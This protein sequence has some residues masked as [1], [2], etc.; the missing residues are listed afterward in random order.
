MA[1][2]LPKGSAGLL[3]DAVC[4]VWPIFG[5]LITLTGLSSGH[6]GDHRRAPASVD[7]AW[8]TLHGLHKGMAKNDKVVLVSS[9]RVALH[10]AYLW[11]ASFKLTHRS[12]L[13][14]W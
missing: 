13:F 11:R 7:G 14:E 6:N 10:P 5:I 8:P 12:L 2:W 4:K 3:K 1:S 9:S